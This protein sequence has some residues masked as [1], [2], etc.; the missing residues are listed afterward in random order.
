MGV[1]DQPSVAIAGLPEQSLQPLRSQRA[2]EKFNHLQ[3]PEIHGADIDAMDKAAATVKPLLELQLA[4]EC[5]AAMGIGEI[6]KLYVAADPTQHVVILSALFFRFSRIQFTPDLLPGDI[7]GTMIFEQGKGSF[8]PHKGPIFAHVLLADEINRAPA[9]VQSALLEGMEELHVTFG[10]ETYPLPDP[11]LVLATQNPLEHEGVF[12]LPEAQLDRFLMKVLI[13]Y[14]SPE[15]EALIVKQYGSV[16]AS[17]S[18][19]IAPVLERKN[20]D[21][22]RTVLDAVSISPEL[23]NYLIKIVNILR[24]NIDAGLPVT[25]EQEIKRSVQFGP[26]PRAVLA[27]HKIARALA[28]IDGRAHV[29]PHDIKRAAMPALRHR[30]IVTYEAEAQGVVP[31]DIIALVLKSVPL[32]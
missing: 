7:T 4:P 23:V 32:P 18:Q 25:L 16:T 31:D 15:E 1:K 2:I 5:D 30:I 29:T 6:G 17:Q 19:T 22:L 3:Q 10:G 20:I 9:K 28:F 26:G 27:M 14:P 12:R 8:I 11:F 13:T 24:K 21:M